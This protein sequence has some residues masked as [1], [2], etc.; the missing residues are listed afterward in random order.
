[1]ALGLE[2]QEDFEVLG[3]RDGQDAWTRHYGKHG[4]RPINRHDLE[5]TTGAVLTVLHTPGTAPF[6][7]ELSSAMALEF[8]IAQ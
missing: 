5:F 4:Q 8:T 3:G 7:L 1:M 6:R 2:I